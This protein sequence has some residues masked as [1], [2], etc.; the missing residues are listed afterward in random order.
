MNVS[1]SVSLSHALSRLIEQVAES[2]ALK[3]QDPAS[4]EILAQLFAER[5]AVEG[6]RKRWLS[7]IWSAFSHL[8]H[9]EFRPGS[10]PPYLSA[11]VAC[12]WEEA[13]ADAEECYRLR[14]M[15]GRSFELLAG[16]AAVRMTGGN[17]W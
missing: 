12:R 16:G 5:S 14:P 15:W 2:A 17:R 3:S 4:V 8:S 9:P 11:S 1:V 10:V 7:E 6:R 13:L